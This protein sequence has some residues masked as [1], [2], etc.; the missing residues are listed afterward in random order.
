MILRNSSTKFRALAGLAILALALMASPAQSA[1]RVALLIGNNAYPGSPLRNAVN[2]ARDLGNALRELGFTTIVK[3]N[4]SRAQMIAALQEFGR[5]L[6]GAEAAL[7]FYAGHAMQ[8]KDRNYL[9]PI[10]AALA[11]EDDVTFFSVDVSQV[12]DRM[13]RAKT[14]FNFVILDACRDN[15]F[16]DSFKVT[17]SGLAQMSGPSGSLIAYATAPGATAADG[18]GRNG[19][20]TGQ[21][22]QNIKVPDMPVEVLFRKVR[23]G[24][25]R[26]TK[27]LQTPWELSSVKGDF[28][29]NATRGGPAQTAGVGGGGPSADTSAQLELQFWRSV[30]NSNRADDVQAYLEKYPSGVYS[31][32]AKNRIDTLLGRAQV[33]MAAPATKPPPAADAGPR[34]APSPAGEKP[35]SVE[36]PRP[37]TGGQ[38][39]PDSA[40]TATA[41]PTPAPTPTPRDESQGREIAP[42]IRELV[43]ADGSVYRGAMRGSQVHGK[44]EYLSKALKYQGEFKDGL[45]HGSGI[46]VWTNGD[47]YEGEF[48]EDK[49]S[50]KGKWQ[51]ANRDSYEG[52]VRAGSITGRGVFISSSGDRIEGSFVD[53]K[54]Q[55]MGVM[56]FANGDRYEGPFRD[57]RPQGRGVM[58]FANGDRY[59]GETEQ[60]TLS[61][62][63]VYFHRNGGRYEGAVVGGLPQ[64]RGTYWFPDGSRFDGSFDQGLAR[65]SGVVVAADGH[66]TKAEIVDG[67]VRLLD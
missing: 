14:R 26:E 24:V 16:R 7:F 58:F 64:G 32:L 11:S 59:E 39:R 34:P 17:A 20:Y 3:E 18:F 19:I 33:A 36:P 5:A 48:V 8:F 65:A 25:E 1:A 29:F 4:V 28:V 40:A 10:D 15:P 55:G 43:Y 37:N 53:C 60:G 62:Q 49:P 42:G 44:G 45:K 51:F 52:E 13:E 54:A 57:S 56:H 41:A 31:R 63:G 21:I 23:E 50:G 2:D 6:D 35:L 30:E 27:R 46:L 61:G 22:L 12:L 9:I 66:R 47:R 67:A 38:P